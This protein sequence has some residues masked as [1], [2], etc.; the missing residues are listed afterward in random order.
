MPRALTK[1]GNEKPVLNGMTVAS[2]CY[3][4]E[5]EI[6]EGKRGAVVTPAFSGKKVTEMGRDMLIRIFA[7]DDCCSKNRISWCQASSNGQGRQEIQAWY[8]SEDK[9]RR[10]D[11]ALRSKCQSV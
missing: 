5:G 4:V 11:P 3:E 2:L 10:D 9:T 6:Q 8:K 7:S 1:P